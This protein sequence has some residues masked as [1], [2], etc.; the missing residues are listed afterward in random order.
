[1]SM[2]N[3]IFE[4]FLKEKLENLKMYEVHLVQN[5][6]GELPLLEQLQKWWKIGILG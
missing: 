6:K 3:K 2:R 5:E 1:M 4:D